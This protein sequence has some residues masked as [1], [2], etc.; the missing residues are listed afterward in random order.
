MPVTVPAKTLAQELK[1]ELGPNFAVPPVDFTNSEYQLPPE[2]GN[3]LHGTIARKTLDDLTSGVVEGTGAFDRI[4]GS[5]KAHLADQYER[6]LISGDQY[7]KAYI[8]MTNM[9]LNA[10][11]QFITGVEQAYWQNALV[12][13]QA[14]RAQVEVVTSRVTMATAKTQHALA[15]VQAELAEAQYVQTMIAISNEDAKYLLAHMQIDLVAEQLEAARAQTLD[16]RTNGAT[17]TGVVGKQK[18]LYTQQI[19]SY[20]KDAAYKVGKMYLDSWLTQK[21]IDEGLAPPTELSNTNVGTVMSK[22]RNSTGLT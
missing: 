17:V 1:T 22:L 8:E 11:M 16:T 9:A 20:Q 13:Q 19:D 15:V 4:M 6:G 14:Q 18:D 21:T 12:Q 10:A 2:L 3:P 7:T 5:L